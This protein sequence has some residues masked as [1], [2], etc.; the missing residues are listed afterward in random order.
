MIP[1]ASCTPG[2][3][4]APISIGA[5]LAISLFKAR[6]RALAERWR[7]KNTLAVAPGSTVYRRTGNASWTPAGSAVPIDYA[8]GSGEAQR[9]RY[10]DGLL[11]TVEENGNLFPAPYAYVLDSSGHFQHVAIFSIPG[12][13]A[14]S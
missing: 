13:R 9:V 5:R 4:T 1:L 8:L 2:R 6:P 12:L 14:R 11:L 7:C 3:A 10:R